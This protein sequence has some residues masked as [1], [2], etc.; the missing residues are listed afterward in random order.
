MKILPVTSIP[1]VLLLIF[2]LIFKVGLLSIKMVEVEGDK[3]SCADENIIKDSARLYRQNFFTLDQNKLNKNL[4]EKFICI[5]DVNLSKDFPDKAIIKIIG[6]QPSA[7][8]VTLK[9]KLASSEATPSADNIS[10]LSV[11]DDEGIVFSKDTE[12]LNIPKIFIYKD[13]NKSFLQILSK[14]KTF[15]INVKDSFINDDFFIVN[16]ENPGPKIIFQLNNRIDI[17]L[18]SLQLILDKAKIDSGKPEFIDLRFDKPV[19]RFAPKK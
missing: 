4:K 11:V 14:I 8:L 13:P 19:V 15:G 7:I 9:E 1:L 2:F 12:N 18:A 16:S 6:R 3:L 17:Q 5:K 10:D